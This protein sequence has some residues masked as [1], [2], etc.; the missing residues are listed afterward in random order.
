MWRH[1]AVSG[2]D[3]HIV[4]C[5]KVLKSSHHLGQIS[6]S[7]Y[8]LYKIHFHEKSDLYFDLFLHFFPA[9]VR[10]ATRCSKLCRKLVRVVGLEGYIVKEM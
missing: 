4:N 8:L 6:L 10:N 9:Q 5:G 7:P 2:V 3:H 1:T